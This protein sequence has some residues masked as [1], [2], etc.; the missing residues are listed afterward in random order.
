MNVL[1]CGDRNIGDGVFLS[2]ISLL[3]HTGAPLRIYLMTAAWDDRCQPLEPAFA[4]RL[5]TYLAERRP[6]SAVTLL[7]ISGRFA[8]EPPAANMDTRFTPGCMLRLYAD[9]CPELPDRILYLDNDVLCCGDPAGLWHTEMTGVEVAGVLD[10]YG[11]YFFRRHPLR[12]D[13]MNSGVLLLNLPEIRR[14]GLFGKCRRL[15]AEKKML[16]PDQSAINRLAKGRKLLDRRF[17]EQ[18]ET[19]TN[20]VFRHFT[21][22]FPVIPGVCP[23]TVKPWDRERMHGALGEYAFDWVLDE[24]QKY[25]DKFQKED[26]CYDSQ[27]GNSRI[28]Y[29]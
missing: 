2:V 27:D 7:D 3:A 21:T 1:F 16:L 23:V 29:H 12:R 20:T 10:R 8:A 4:R 24:Y 25:K 9:L 15:C 22:F 13:Y 19:K 5:E 17:N 14:T 11:S 18:S 28:L 6:G 26:T